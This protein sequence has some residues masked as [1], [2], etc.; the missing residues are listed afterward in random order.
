PKGH[1]LFHQEE[2]AGLSQLMGHYVAG[3]VANLPELMVLFCP[4]INSYKR[5]VP[6]VWAPVNSTW[7]IDNRTAA[8]RV[9]PSGPKSTRVETRLAG[10]DANPY[11]AMAASLAAGL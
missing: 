3:V 2:G 4:T 6:G 8:V 10:A 9:I 1:N 5:T 11:L 7:G